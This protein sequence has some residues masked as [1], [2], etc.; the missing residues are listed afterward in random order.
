MELKV[1]NVQ[2]IGI[3]QHFGLGNGFLNKT[4]KT[5]VNKEKNK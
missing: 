1:E 5:R 4:P 2:K 3:Y